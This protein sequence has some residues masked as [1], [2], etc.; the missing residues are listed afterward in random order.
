MRFST[1]LRQLSPLLLG[2]VGCN[3]LTSPNGPPDLTVVQ[4]VDLGTIAEGSGVSGRDGGTST[5]FQGASF[6]LYNDTFFSHPNAQNLSLV[7]DSW[8][9]TTNVDA[10]HGITG[11]QEHDDATGDVTMFLP[12]LPSEQTF[13]AQHNPN[14]CTLEPCGERW[15]PWI[16]SMVADA[17][18][19]RAI[20]FY[21]LI[22]ADT[23]GG[24]TGPGVGIATWGGLGQ[25]PVRPTLSYDPQNPDM[26]FL[27]GEPDW[28]A[29]SLIVGGTL[30][31]LSCGSADN[32][33]CLLARV[34][35]A[36]IYDRSAWTY[37]TGN[38]NWSSTMNAAVT[39]FEGN[40]ILNVS[41]NGYLQRY[42][43]IYS[44]PLSNDV[45]ART[46][47]RLEGPWSSDIRLF[48]AM[49]PGDGSAV[50][51][52][53]SHP[54]FNADGGQTMYVAYSRAL[55]VSG[56]EIRQVSVTFHRP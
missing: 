42:I 21:D 40:D 6:W 20:I 44:S 54:E 53:Q 1:R 27:Q 34:D 3:Q 39:L 16:A 52:A 13:N 41:W 46:A 15:A 38:G 23:L 11:F 56:A 28:G 17:A 32:K 31:A 37:Y 29:A 35:P 4:T 8:A 10:S 12:L 45:M 5:L 24:W 25:T 49:T 19:N 26:V 9:W 7:G 36:R 2:I 30:Y 48:T 18:R 14:A 50:Y 33:P 22:H 51:D 43:A 55:P 47:P